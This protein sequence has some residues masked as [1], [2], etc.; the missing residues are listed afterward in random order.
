MEH[1]RLHKDKAVQTCMEKELLSVFRLHLSLWQAQQNKLSY[2]FKAL[3]SCNLRPN[4]AVAGQGTF[5]QGNST[6]GCWDTWASNRV[7]PVCAESC[8]R[9]VTR[10]SVWILSRSWEGLG[11]SALNVGVWPNFGWDS[12]PLNLSSVKVKTIIDS[13]AVYGKVSALEPKRPI[14]F[15]CVDWDLRGSP[16][17]DRAQG[18]VLTLWGC[19]CARE[20]ISMCTLHVCAL[21]ESSCNTCLCVYGGVLHPQLLINAIEWT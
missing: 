11:F 1:N 2:M 19:L 12:E 9:G 7:K 20:L 16:G 21:R 18:A 14:A 17:A 4:Q 8:T 10:L 13:I 3:D 15:H 5:L 6:Q